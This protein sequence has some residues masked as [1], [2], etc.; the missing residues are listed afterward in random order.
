M[1]VSKLRT[2]V[3]VFALLFYF[4][5][6]YYVS[7]EYGAK[8]KI[9]V[10][11]GRQA[12][13]PLKGLIMSL[14]ANIPN[15][16]FGVLAVVLCSITLYGNADVKDIFALV[17]AITMAH[18]SMYMGIIQTFVYGFTL[19]NPDVPDM[20]K[21]LIMSVLF[22]LMPLISVGVTQFGYFLGTKEKKILSIF[23]GKK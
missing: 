21:Y 20:N 13:L 1:L 8:D 7:W 17:F 22:L 3:S 14:I 2:I 23:S 11:S 16:I 12:A 9:R 10:D 6:L 19:P 5:L 15:L 4:A 18:A